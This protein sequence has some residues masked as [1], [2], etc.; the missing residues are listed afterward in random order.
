MEVAVAR[1]L[2]SVKVAVGPGGIEVGAW[3]RDSPESF[4]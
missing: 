2:G 1:F 3:V 4:D